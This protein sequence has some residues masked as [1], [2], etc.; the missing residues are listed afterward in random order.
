MSL[1]DFP[2]TERKTV[3]SICSSGFEA[4]PPVCLY[5]SDLEAEGPMVRGRGHGKEFRPSSL[6]RAC[7]SSSVE[8][9][10]SQASNLL[11]FLPHAASRVSPAPGP[12]LTTSP[13]C[14]KPSGLALSQRSP[15]PPM[16]GQE[17]AS[18]VHQ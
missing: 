16:P 5:A 11:P 1:V 3:S 12:V 14:F 9:S 8:P 13:P 6:L 2:V 7:H 18:E 15:S 10:M 4:G 17:L